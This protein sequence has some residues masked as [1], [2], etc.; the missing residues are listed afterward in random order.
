MK[1]LHDNSASERAGIAMK[2]K[3]RFAMRNRIQFS[4]VLAFKRVRRSLGQNLLQTCFRKM[5][6]LFLLI[7]VIK[8]VTSEEEKNVKRILALGGNGFIGSAVLHNLL[9][10]GLYKEVSLLSGPTT[11][12]FSIFWYFSNQ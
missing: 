11:D 4:H 2:R 5:K 7:F 3:Q 10:K 12:S 1:L 8:I 9:S 6:K